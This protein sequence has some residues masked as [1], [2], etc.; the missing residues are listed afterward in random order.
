MAKA[1]YD[2]LFK[3]YALVDLSKYKTGQIGMRWRTQDEVFSGKGQF[4]CASLKCDATQLKTFEVT[5]LSI[6]FEL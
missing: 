4:T 3:E 2:R 5:I 1:Y 6:H